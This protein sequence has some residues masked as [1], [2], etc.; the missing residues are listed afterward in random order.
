[1]DKPVVYIL[2]CVNGMYYIGST[3]DILRRMEE[4]GR[5]HT[6]SLRALLPVELVFQQ[7]YENIAAARKIEYRL[8]QLKSRQIIERIV[9]DKKINM[10]P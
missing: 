2:K 10:Q 7:E 1:M 4:H 6:E 8:K 5:G 9:R 3:M